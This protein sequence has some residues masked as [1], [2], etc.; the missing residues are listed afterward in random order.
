MAQVNNLQFGVTVD[1]WVRKTEQRMLAVFRESVQRLTS[2][3]I[4]RTPVD[5][6][7]LKS[8]VVASLQ[9]MPQVN[10]NAKGVAGSSYSVDVGAIATVLAGAK[11]GDVAYIGWVA[12]YGPIIEA[13][14]S[15]QAPAGFVRVS[16]LEWPRIVSEVTQEA[17]GRAG[18]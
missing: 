1:A 11:I 7:Y 18:G 10:P 3:A 14:H 8:S 12:S 16:A 13:G 4:A 17:K 6:G 9:Q 2:N 5:T 15:K